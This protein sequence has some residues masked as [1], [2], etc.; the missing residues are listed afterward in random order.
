MANGYN[1]LVLP[2]IAIPVPHSGDAAYAER[3]LP[4]YERAVEL[5]GG[6][7]IR[8]PLNGPMLEK[9][10]ADCAAVLL[11]GSRADIEPSLYGAKRS[12]KTAASDDLRYAAD[13]LLLEDA[14]AAKKPVLGICY[15]LQS[16]NVYC[17]GSLIQDIDDFLPSQKRGIQHEAGRR[18]A[19]AHPIQV[20]PGSL[21]RRVLGYGSDAPLTIPVNSSHHQSVETPGH[22]LRIGAICPAD[23]IVEAV[24]GDD[25]QHFVLAVQWHPERSVEE[26]DPRLREPALAIFRALVQAVRRAS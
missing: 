9:T 17:R 3:A 12:G 2:R 10:I 22:G 11:P 25:P 16:L 19:N 13:R 26:E 7:P 4:Q 15:G 5:A 8:V 21:L 6:I 14:Y 20:E 1:I 23:G 24:E 18:V